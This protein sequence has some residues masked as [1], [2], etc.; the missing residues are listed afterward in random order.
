MCKEIGY[1]RGWESERKGRR[2]WGVIQAGIAFPS[3]VGQRPVLSSYH[4]GDRREEEYGEGRK[5]GEEEKSLYGRHSTPIRGR[6]HKN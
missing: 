4:G 2:V 5:E 3:G 6:R 1:V